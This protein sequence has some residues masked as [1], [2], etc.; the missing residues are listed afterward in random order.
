[1]KLKYVKKDINN[2][3]KEIQDKTGKLAETLK[4]KTQ[5]TI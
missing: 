4:K 3:F 1:M 2:Y 5:K